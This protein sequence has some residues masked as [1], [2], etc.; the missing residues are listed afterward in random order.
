L[1]DELVLAPELGPREENVDAKLQLVRALPGDDVFKPFESSH[2]HERSNRRADRKFTISRV[3]RAPTSGRVAA[4]AAC[5]VAGC[6]KSC[7]A[8]ARPK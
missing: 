7:H 1:I 8:V 2:A 6:R 5:A 4:F 3:I